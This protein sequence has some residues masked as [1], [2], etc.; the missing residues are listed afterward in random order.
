MARLFYLLRQ[1]TE[2]KRWLTIPSMDKPT[3]TKKEKSVELKALETE[4]ERRVT[5]V[6]WLGFEILLI[7]GIPAG[8]GAWFGSRYENSN[9]LMGVLLGTFILSWIIVSVRYRKISAQ[10]K[11]LDDMIRAKKRE[12]GIIE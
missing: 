6:F 3:I 1:A 4:R 10:M 9:I 2:S 7:F 11:T 12:E 8:L 5:R